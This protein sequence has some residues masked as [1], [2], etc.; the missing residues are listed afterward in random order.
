MRRET[1]NDQL[2]MAG[3]AKCKG[4]PAILQVGFMPAPDGV[5]VRVEKL[6]DPSAAF[7]IVQQQDRVYA[8]RNAVVLAL[9]ADASLKFKALC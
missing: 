7:P 6:C 9:T 4:I 1:S 2:K 3:S 5:V 8:A